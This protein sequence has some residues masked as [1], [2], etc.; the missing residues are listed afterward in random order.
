MEEMIYLIVVIFGIIQLA[1]IVKIWKM[2]TATDKIKERLFLISDRVIPEEYRK[3][4]VVKK[5]FEQIQYLYR[6]HPSNN[7]DKINSKMNTIF[8]TQEQWFLDLIDD[9]LL[10]DVF[11]LDELKEIITKYFIK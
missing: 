10:S 1:L 8:N 9:H 2:A 11:T 4:A 6:L 3:R 5:A 7:A